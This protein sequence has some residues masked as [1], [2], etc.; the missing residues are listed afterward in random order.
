MKTR[1]VLE[2]MLLIG[3]PAAVLFAGVLTTV[4]AYQRGFTPV[5]GAE[6]IVGTR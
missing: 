4:L 1:P 5:A 6:R 2:L 3:L